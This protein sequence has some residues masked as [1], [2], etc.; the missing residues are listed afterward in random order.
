MA[1]RATWVSFILAQVWWGWKPSNVMPV[2][3]GI[4]F[5]EKSLT[6]PF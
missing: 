3:L 6:T 2:K 5:N 4:F 1:V